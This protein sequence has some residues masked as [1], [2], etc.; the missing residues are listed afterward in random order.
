M[1]RTYKEL[2]FKLNAAFKPEREAIASKKANIITWKGQAEN[3]NR[4][5]DMAIRDRRRA[6][7]KACSTSSSPKARVRFQLAD[8]PLS[9]NKHISSH[10]LS[11]MMNMAISTKPN[12]ME[13]NPLASSYNIV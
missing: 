11:K 13:E 9:C 12:K 2:N 4:D 5:L 10:N 3:K 8:Q 1:S 7:G 6:E